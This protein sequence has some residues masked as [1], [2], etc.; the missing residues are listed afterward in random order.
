MLPALRGFVRPGVQRASPGEM[1]GS[2][3]VGSVRDPLIGAFW[4]VKNRF[5]R[6]NT[7]FF[8]GLNLACFRILPEA[9]KN[10]GK[11]EGFS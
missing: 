3:V 9:S 8:V 1:R 5:A 4:G 11:E 10:T 2:S 6:E 7:V